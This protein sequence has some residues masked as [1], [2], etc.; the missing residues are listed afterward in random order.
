MTRACHWR[1]QRT[2]GETTLGTTAR[3]RFQISNPIDQSRMKAEIKDGV[4]RLGRRQRR[5]KSGRE[6]E[7]EHNWSIR[8]QRRMTG[9]K[10]WLADERVGAHYS[11][12]TLLDLRRER[13]HVTGSKKCCGLGRYRPVCIKALLSVFGN[14]TATGHI[15][16][17]EPR[18]VH[19]ADRHSIAE[20]HQTFGLDAPFRPRPGGY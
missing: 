17:V 5:T 20:I 8:L 18:A 14:S 2:P 11:R 9:E 19:R 4:V 16:E 1:S 13:P 15:K 12:T 3:R 6:D 7:I 10:G